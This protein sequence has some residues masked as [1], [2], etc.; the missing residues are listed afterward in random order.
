MTYGFPFDEVR[1]ITCEP[2]GPDY[3]DYTNTV[4]NDAMANISLTLLD[5]IDTLI[6]MKQWDDLEYAL[7]YLK[8]NQPGFFNQ[9]SIVQVFETTIRFLGGLLSTHLLLT[10]VTKNVPLPTS[11]DRLKA[12]SAKYDGFLLD[13]AY[14]LGLRLIPSYKT[15]THIPFPRINLKTGLKKVPPALQKDACTSGV[16]TPVLEFT[17]LSRLTGDYQFE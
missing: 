9:D 5:N 8:D 16:T 6:I 17:L 12:I 2:Y 4:R 13:M 14:D 1:P 3:R 11:Y 15:K 10:D 7:R